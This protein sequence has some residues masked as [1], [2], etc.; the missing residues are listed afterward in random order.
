MALAIVERPLPEII[1][2]P[3]PNPDELPAWVQMALGRHEIGKSVY[4][5]YNALKELYAVLQQSYSSRIETEVFKKLRVQALAWQQANYRTYITA[6]EKQILDAEIIAL[7]K[8]YATKRYEYQR[9]VLSIHGEYEWVTEESWQ[10]DTDWIISFIQKRLG[11][12]GVIMG[13]H[14]ILQTLT[15][16]SAVY[17]ACELIGVTTVI[18]A[19]HREYIEKKRKMLHFALQRAA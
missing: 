5:G 11:S 4:I 6:F 14:Q 8:P 2:L 16:V 15:S 17:Y 9:Q 12:Y 10:H 19:S 7:E 3:L 1:Q 18:M 13:K